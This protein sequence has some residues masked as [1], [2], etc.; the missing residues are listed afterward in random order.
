M[1]LVLVE[2]EIALGG[3]GECA[4]GVDGVIVVI[5]GCCVEMDIVD[6]D[7]C[8]IGAVLVG[9]TGPDEEKGH[10]EG[11]LLKNESDSKRRFIAAE[12][13]ERHMVGTGRGKPGSW[14]K[15]SLRMTMDDVEC[16][17]FPIRKDE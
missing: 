15:P 14:R 1:G 5:E 17:N 9:Q 10:F 7:V 16:I 12:H 3:I 2:G 11:W 6:Y 8:C 13:G 4:V